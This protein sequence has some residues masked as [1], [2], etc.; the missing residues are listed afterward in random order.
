MTY[1]NLW[2]MGS[3]YV[4]ILELVKLNIKHHYSIV[5]GYILC[6]MHLYNKTKKMDSISVKTNKH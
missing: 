5:F 2:A 1:Y 6:I 3:I 4:V